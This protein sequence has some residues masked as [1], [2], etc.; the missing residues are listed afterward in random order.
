MPD[1]PL[2]LVTKNV[3]VVRPA[4]GRYVPR[5]WGGRQAP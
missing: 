5:P 3:R 4:R 1:R 2:D